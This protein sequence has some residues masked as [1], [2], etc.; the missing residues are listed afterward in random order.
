MTTMGKR[1]RERKLGKK[2]IT[3]GHH[4]VF[5]RWVEKKYNFDFLDGWAGAASR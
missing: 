1:E 5:S 2:M 3:L 4:F